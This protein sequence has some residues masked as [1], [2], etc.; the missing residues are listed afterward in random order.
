ML[1]HFVKSMNIAK[2][3]KF[4]GHFRFREVDVQPKYD[5]KNCLGKSNETVNCFS[6]ICP[7]TFLSN[8]LRKPLVKLFSLVVQC[9][10][11]RYTKAKQLSLELLHQYKYHLTEIESINILFQAYR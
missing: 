9:F 6:K 8:I 3:C 2:I 5:G 11:E 4:I 7:G 10:T 1:S